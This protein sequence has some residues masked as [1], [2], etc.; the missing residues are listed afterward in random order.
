M[1]MQTFE[2]APSLVFTLLEAAAM[3]GDDALL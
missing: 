3:L 1:P 2:V